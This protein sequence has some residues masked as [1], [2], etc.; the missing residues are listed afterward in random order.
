MRRAPADQE[1]RRRLLD[2]ATRLF[3]ER[4]YWHVT[5]REICAAARANVAAVNYH[6][7]DKMGLYREVIDSAAAVARESTA[8]AI[9]AGAGVSPREQL[10]RY[11]DVLYRRMS[12]A[13]GPLYLQQI[14]HREMTEPTGAVT[15]LVDRLLKG[16]FEYL[17]QVIG[18]MLRLPPTD[19][20]VALAAT[21]IHGMIIMHRPTPLSERIGKALQ[22]SFTPADVSAHLVQFALGGLDSYAADG[23]ARE[24]VVR[25]SRRAGRRPPV[26]EQH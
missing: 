24:A 19:A 10:C 21:T 8:L 6:F 22:L 4:G 20:R 25:R 12:S 1:T 11:I 18:A 15:T 16:R 17:Q 13:T 14:V 23:R 5:V 2:A 3:A 26:A 9:R 7:G